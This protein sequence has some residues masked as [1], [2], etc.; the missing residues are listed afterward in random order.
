MAVKCVIKHSVNIAVLEY[1][2]ACI[3][4]SAIILVVCVMRHSV[5][6]AI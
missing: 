1:I 4:V 6:R 2:Y 5:T 3:M